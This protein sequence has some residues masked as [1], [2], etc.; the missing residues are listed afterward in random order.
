[1]II[2]TLVVAANTH[3][4]NFSSAPVFVFLS[5]QLGGYIGIQKRIK[6]LSSDDL[7]LFASS[8]IYTILIPMVGGVLAIFLCLVF[9][10]GII[11]GNLFPKFVDDILPIGEVR[12][13]GFWELFDH[14]GKS[15]T[16]YA[17]LL[18]WSFIAGYSE[19][20]V[21]GIINSFANDK[22]KVK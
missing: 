17:K 16:D 4:G 18:C 5:G 20:F 10:S 21:V 2:I 13:E 12:N 15:Y 1:M 14:N 22:V 11:T 19:K 3:L 9:V 6:K 8:W 7:L